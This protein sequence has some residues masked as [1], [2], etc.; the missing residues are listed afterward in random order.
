[1]C[2]SS[3]NDWAGY[4]PTFATQREKRSCLCWQGIS[5]GQVARVAIALLV[6]AMLAFA[7][8]RRLRRAAWRRNRGSL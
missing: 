5:R 6:F 2:L 4:S 1:M 8:S 3:A 7:A